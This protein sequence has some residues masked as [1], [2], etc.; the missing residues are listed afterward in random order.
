MNALPAIIAQHLHHQG[1]EVKTFQRVSGGCINSG[2]KI[3]TAKGDFFLKWNDAEKFP[4][5]FNA[6][7]KGLQVLKHTG[8]VRVPEVVLV[9]QTENLQYLLLEWITSATPSKKFWIGLGEQLANLHRHSQPHFGLGHNNYIGSLPQRNTPTQNWIQFF[10]EHRLEPQ[11]ALLKHASIRTGMQAVIKRLP[12]LL[13]AETP[14]LLHGDLWSGNVMADEKGLPCLIDPAC[15]FGNREIE[16]AFTQLFGGFDATFYS[17]YQANLPL[18]PGFDERVD[19]YHLYPLLV[20]A[21]LFG[22]SYL[23]QVERIIKRYQ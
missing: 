2:G 19:V 12:H 11:L 13:P 21:N 15:Y 4:G 6:E 8:S 18:L 9:G 17:A 7:A 22:G 14:A 5:M 10:I 3:A 20:H 1:I 23:S 16:L